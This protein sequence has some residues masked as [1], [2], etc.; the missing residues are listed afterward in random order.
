[1]ATR[2]SDGSV[3]VQ[4]SFVP[5]ELR[6]FAGRS[7]RRTEGQRVER[8][9]ERPFLPRR[10]WTGRRPN[11]SSV[12]GTPKVSDGA[13][14]VP[15]MLQRIAGNAWT[16][17]QRGFDAADHRVYESLF[18]LGNGNFGGRGTHEERYSGDSLQ[19]NYLAVARLPRPL[20]RRLAVGHGHTRFGRG[21]E[22]R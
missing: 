10:E 4:P 21:R 14:R 19:G 17:E 13:C 5:V 2:T 11:R 8:W 3:H 12:R 22:P 7:P 16:I 9:A 6:L 15:Y 1:M 20:P 18:S